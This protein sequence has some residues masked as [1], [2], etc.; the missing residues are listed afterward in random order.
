MKNFFI[1][2]NSYKDENAQFAKEC[3]SHI[4]S[5]GGTADY[6]LSTGE[7]DNA[8][9]IDVNT[10]P[11]GTQAVIVLGGDGTLIHAAHDIAPAGIP[12]LGVNLGHTGYLCDVDKGSIKDVARR[13]IE[14][15]F[16]IEKRMML[17]GEMGGSSDDMDALNDIVIHRVGVLQ[18]VNLVVYVDGEYL[19]SFDGDG[20]IVSSPTGSTAYNLSAGG[21]IVDPNA[22]VILI[23]PINAHNVSARTIVIDGDSEV[24]IEIG[25]RRR[26]KDE[27]VMVSFDGDRHRIMSVSDRIVIRRSKDDAKI[28]K[29]SK[30]GFLETLRKKLG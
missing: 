18:M 10:I 2:T 28:I 5:Y 3:C 17:R 21:P 4:K 19:H 9:C 15:D 25:S 29:L 20:V 27:N 30:A 14:D 13:L 11:H 23:T 16:V 8:R 7:K 12:I 22:K 26:E 24:V 6:F 1:I